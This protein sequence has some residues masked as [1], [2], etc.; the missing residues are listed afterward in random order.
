MDSIMAYAIPFFFLTIGIELLVGYLNK[1][2]YYNFNDAITNLNIGIGSQTVGLVTKLLMLGA[3]SLVYKHFALVRI[4]LDNVYVFTGLWIAT[5][6]VFDCI[7]YWAHRFGHEWNVMWGAHIVHH[8]SE[9]FN[10]SVALRQSWFHSFFSFWMFL[11][12]ALI[13]PTEIL[14][15]V[16][17]LVTL[18]QYWIHTEAINKMPRWFEFIFNTPSHHRVHHATNPQYID[19]NYAAVFIIWDRLFGTFE[20]EVEKPNYGITVGHTSLDPIYANVHYYKE[21]ILGAKKEKGF[22]KK[23]TLMFKGP[24]YLGALIQDYY[25]SQPQKQPAPV[26]LNMRIYVLIQFIAL[27]VGLVLYMLEFGNLSTFYKV[28]G[29][30]MIILTIQ[31]CGYILENKS[32]LF[33]LEII[34]LILAAVLL[35]AVYYEWYQ[36]WFILALVLSLSIGTV[37]TSWFVYENYIRR[38]HPIKVSNS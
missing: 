13:V 1:K 6:I 32:K 18:F 31:S 22:W 27:S 20:P 26:S 2:N 5:L 19:K 23:F 15:G 21:M 10:L 37:S 24:A 9:E 3:Y 38:K 28:A 11:P 34:R 17:G 8:Q 25:K 7:Y 35:N 4:P 30:A 36:V 14:A 33:P 29:L 12:L 16:I